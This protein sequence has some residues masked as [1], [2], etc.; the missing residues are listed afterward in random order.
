MAIGFKRIP[1]I[2]IIDTSGGTIGSWQDR[3][4]AGGLEGNI[5]QILLQKS[6][7]VPGNFSNKLVIPML[8]NPQSFS[9]TKNPRV[10]K[11]LT[12]KGLLIQS[13]QSDPDMVNISG[14]AAS[15]KA[16]YVLSQLDALS[17]TLE[18]GTRNIVTM[19]YKFGGIYRGYIENFKTAIDSQQPG[20]FD[21]SFDFQFIDQ[22]HFRLFLMSLKTSSLNDAINNRG[23]AFTEQ[24][25]LS[26]KNLTGN[27]SIGK[28]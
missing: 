4:S 13:W 28:I 23:K 18:N 2:F 12:K 10:T 1:L 14:R 27:M 26:A 17:K 19:V 5:Y 15:S 3:I 6:N 7:L 11:T 21:Y 20:I 8:V 9:V 22:N 25:H 24:L 16:F